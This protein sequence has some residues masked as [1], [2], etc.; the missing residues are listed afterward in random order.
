[1][2]TINRINK[3]GGGIALITKDEAKIT[4]LDT[5]NYTSFE[6]KHGMY[7]SNQSQPIL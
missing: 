1:M 2:Q 7:S 6:Q 3:R 5:N 4:G